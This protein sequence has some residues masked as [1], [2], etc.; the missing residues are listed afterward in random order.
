MVLMIGVFL[1]LFLFNAVSAL[2][3][4]SSYK[5]E[6]AH[7]ENKNDLGSFAL[8]VTIEVGNES[9][10]ECA[11]APCAKIYLED[12]ENGRQEI[13]FNYPMNSGESYSETVYLTYSVNP[14]NLDVFI[15]AGSTDGLQISQINVAGYQYFLA[16]TWYGSKSNFWIDGDYNFESGDINY[17]CTNGVICKLCYNCN[18]FNSVASIP[19]GDSE[20]INF[21]HVKNNSSSTKITGEKGNSFQIMATIQVGTY[22]GANTDCGLIV[23]LDDAQNGRIELQF[24]A[25]IS[26]G[27]YY[28]YVDVPYAT[29]PSN[30]NVLI[31]S[32]N[33]ND[34]T[35]IDEITVNGYQYYLADTTYGA[36]N[37]FWVDGDYNSDPPANY[38][39]QNGIVCELCWNC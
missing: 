21:E 6:S 12:A 26:G 28:Q 27:L 14:S 30:M 18:D 4:P 34:A 31:S 35:Q 8:T 22:A 17:F 32:G 36:L 29:N 23:Y 39:C 11:T 15:S 20:K 9:E 25:M 3:P 16:D 5:L 33:C 13:Q 10:A 2:P 19:Y 1:V 24:P 7:S 38:Y 37:Y